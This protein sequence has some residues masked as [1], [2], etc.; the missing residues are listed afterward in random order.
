MLNAAAVTACLLALLGLGLSAS[1]ED[2]SHCFYRQMLPGGPSSSGA[3]RRHCHR[4]PGG[5]AFAT[6]HRPTCDTAAVSAFHLGHVGT[7]GEEPAA[8]VLW[9]S[10]VTS[11][12][13]SSVG[14]R[15]SS[16]PGDL[17]VLTGQG[18]LGAEAGYEEAG[19]LFW[20]AMCCDVPP[21]SGEKGFAVALVR[22]AQGGEEQKEVSVE[23]LEEMLGV[24]ELFSGGCGRASVEGLMV[25]ARGVAVAQDAA[26]ENVEHLED[27]PGTAQHS[28]GEEITE[29]EARRSAEAQGQAPDDPT[30]Q[31][32]AKRSSGAPAQAAAD[33]DDDDDDEATSGHSSKA[34]EAAEVETEPE[35]VERNSTIVYLI[36]TSVYV[37]TLPLRPVVSAITSIPGQVAYVLQEDLC[38]LAGLPGDTCYLFYLVTCGAFSWIR[39]AVSL[40]LDLVWGCICGMYHCTWAMLAELLGSCYAGLAGVGTLAGDSLG[41]VGDAV[42]NAWWVTRLLGGRLWEN[43]EGYVGSVASEMGGQ[44][45]NVGGGL[46]K[47]VWRSLKGVGH[48]IRF[49]LTVIL[50]TVRMIALGIL[51]PSTTQDDPPALV[52]PLVNAE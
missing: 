30:A 48:V 25:G 18:R 20:S 42:D 10:S 15:C 13:R 21:E 38:V 40:V 49:T 52:V 47:L 39:S 22:E 6:L 24:T 43:S 1:A 19:P 45:M 46:G 33:D 7:G 4:A 37:L 36:S 26:T 34:E 2:C 51:D 50:G 8:V 11:M 9:D 44:A 35:E 5:Q 28:A 23:Q 17:Y 29:Q 16:L 32:E 27:H 31:Q 41:I 12:V 14:P 3:L